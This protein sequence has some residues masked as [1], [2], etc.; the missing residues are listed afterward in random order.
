MTEFVFCHR[1]TYW[2][3]CARGINSFSNYK[4]VVIASIMG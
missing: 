2:K 4:L 1:L 3:N